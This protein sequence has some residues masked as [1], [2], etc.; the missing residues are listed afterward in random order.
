MADKTDDPA[1]TPAAVLASNLRIFSSKLK[2][3]LREQAS[4]GDLTLS[5]AA[6]LG[7]L[8][9]DGPTTV[10]ELARAEGMRPQSMGTIVAAL[11]AAGHVSGTPDPT[12]G[13]RT[14]LAVT[15]AC[16]A[17]IKDARAA[18]EDWLLRAVQTHLTPAEQ[19]ELNRALILLGR[20]VDS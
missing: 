13:R 16:R 3:R 12:D 2:R 15:D 5:Q 7:R 19:D 4:L 6:V 8:E 14:I 11:E 9:R 17:W 10:S 1:E 20:I 18:R